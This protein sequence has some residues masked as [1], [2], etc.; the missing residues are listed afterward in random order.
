MTNRRVFLQ[1][2]VATSALPAAIR[3][4]V[5]DARASSTG[6]HGHERLYKAVFDERF[7]SSVEFARQVDQFGIPVHGIQGD[8]TSLWYRDLSILWRT[9]PTAIAGL[10]TAWPLLCLELMARD[11]GLRVVFRAEHDYHSDTML[12]HRLSGPASV[13]HGEWRE[14]ALPWPRSMA[15]L[16][17]GFPHRRDRS[18]E[19]A[20]SVPAS[21]PTA[22]PQRLVSWII[23]PNRRA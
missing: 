1:M 17:A 20:V 23:A 4:A 16:V 10:T 14:R 9:T 19:S 12:E 2:A 11:H 5:P 22:D 18:T 21:K 13:I 6:E 8:V 15:R 7:P 3:F